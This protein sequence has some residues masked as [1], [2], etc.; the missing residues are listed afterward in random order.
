MIDGNKLLSKVDCSRGAP[1]G[2]MNISDDPE[3]TVTLFRMHMVEGY[4]DGGAYWGG[5]EENPVYAA[6]GKGFEFYVW[7]NG[8]NDAKT[9]LL[10]SHPDL[11]IEMTEVNDDFLE[12]YITAALW[13]SNDESDESGGNPLDQNYSRDDIAPELMEKMIEDCRKFLEKCGHL[14][15]EEN[16]VGRGEMFSQA[17][18]DFWLTRC[19]HG[20]GFFDGDWKEPAATI[21]TDVCNEFGECWLTVE[22]DGKIYGL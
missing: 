11:K 2:R 3:A 5:D 12:G 1:M 21:L 9:K 15:T 14:I 6:I 4:D 19:G 10:G 18:H 7:A 13:S 22:E 16:M 17:G 20:C 8:L